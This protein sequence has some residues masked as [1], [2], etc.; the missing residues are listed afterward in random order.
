LLGLWVRIPPGTCMSVSCECCVLSSRSLCVGLITLQRIPTE[1]GVS[2]C[3]REALIMRRPWPTRGCCV[4]EKN[5]DHL[6]FLVYRTGVPAHSSRFDLHITAKGR[7]PRLLTR[8]VYTCSP[9]TT[10]Q[11]CVVK[12]SMAITSCSVCVTVALKV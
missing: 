11:N 5:P 3:D 10:E 4:M 6:L 8:S 2:E 9:D 1:C 7:H 12:C